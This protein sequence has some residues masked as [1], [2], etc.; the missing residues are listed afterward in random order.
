[1]INTITREKIKERMDNSQPITLVEALPALYYDAEHLPGAIN[2]PH[3]EIRDKADSMLPDKEDCIVVY[4]AN[5]P[6]PNSKIAANTLQ[7]IGY[8]HVYEYVEGKQDWIEA[9]FTVE[10][11]TVREAG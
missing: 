8:Q 7:Q 3:D 6:C 2:I 10:K 9:G 11:S 1:M 4:C 5:T